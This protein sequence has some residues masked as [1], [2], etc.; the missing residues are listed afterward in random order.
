MSLLEK[1]KLV[2]PAVLFR[3]VMGAEKKPGMGNRKFPGMV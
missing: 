2:C 3:V 1:M